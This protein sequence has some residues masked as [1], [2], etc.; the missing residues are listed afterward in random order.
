MCAHMLFIHAILG[1]SITFRLFGFGKGLTLKEIKSDALIKRLRGPASRGARGAWGGMTKPV[2]I[3]TIYR[4]PR[5]LKD[6]VKQCI[7]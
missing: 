3:E 1:F 6:N 7:T 2:I 5:N 4:L